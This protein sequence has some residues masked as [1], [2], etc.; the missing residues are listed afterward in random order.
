M[1]DAKTLDYS[2]NEEDLGFGEPPKA[3]KS[4]L[5]FGEKFSLALIALGLLAFIIQLLGA[6]FK[7]TWFG[8]LIS[9]AP[10]VIGTPL[11]FYIS[12]KD[13][14]P[15]IKHNN[16]YFNSL[17]ARGALGWAAGI[18]ITG[19]YIILYWWP[20]YL[21]GGIKIVDPLSRVLSGGPANRWFFYG[22]LYT[23]AIL[24]FGIRMFIKYRHNK[25][26]IIRTASVMFFQLG[27]AF[28]IP[29]ILKALNQPEFYFTY[30]WPLKYSYLFP[31][32]FKSFVNHPE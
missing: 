19:F 8:F 11:Y 21:A 15:G 29:N 25:Y 13:T 1:I 16:I 17:S 20:Q 28:I 30:F 4:E 14:E 31:D 6:P 12:F 3:E 27:F 24:M 5:K 26:Q 23:I 9:F 7:G 32:T 22:F 10:I 18:L 2:F